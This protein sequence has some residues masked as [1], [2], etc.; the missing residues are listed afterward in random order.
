MLCASVSAYEVYDVNVYEWNNGSLHT[1]SGSSTD[2]SEFSANEKKR[3]IFKFSDYNKW[4]LNVMQHTFAG[5]HSRFSTTQHCSKRQNGY[6][7]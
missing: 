7:S 2:A 3:I 4:E 5:I 6:K 1:M